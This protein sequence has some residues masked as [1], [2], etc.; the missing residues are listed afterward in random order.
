MNNSKI[1]VKLNMN[2][3]EKEEKVKQLY[4]KSYEIYYHVKNALS[5]KKS[6]YS[7]MTLNK[8][9]EIN[10]YKIDRNIQKIIYSGRLNNNS[11]FF[12]DSKCIN[13]I[14]IEI[15]SV[16]NQTLSLN[17]LLDEFQLLK[18]HLRGQNL[19]SSFKIIMMISNFSIWLQAL[20]LIVNK[21]CHSAT[22][23]HLVKKP[24]LLSFLNYLKSKNFGDE[25]KNS[26]FT[27]IKIICFTNLLYRCLSIKQYEYAYLIAEKLALPFM[28]KI[29]ISHSRLNKFLGISYLARNKLELENSQSGEAEDT[30]I[31]DINKIISSSNFVLAQQN[32]QILVK[33]IDQLLENNNLNSDYMKE[34]NSLEINLPRNNL[35]IV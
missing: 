5:S 8:I 3:F 16:F 7:N 35:L 22:N 25:G 17:P 34:N 1:S 15:S 11:M 9:N 12:F 10:D 26:T 2:T 18:N 21:L 19:E 6:N 4:L 30:I 29:I 33:D 28:Y 14:F 20:L 24:S 31:N 23:I 13:G 27:N 32:M